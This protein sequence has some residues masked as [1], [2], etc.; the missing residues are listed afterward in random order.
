MSL[1]GIRII[2]SHLSGADS[3]S[4]AP[5]NQNIRSTPTNVDPNQ[6]HTR[7]TFSKRCITPFGDETGW[8]G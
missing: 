3:D 8:N 5:Q 1:I 7:R 2:L 4:R 6:Y